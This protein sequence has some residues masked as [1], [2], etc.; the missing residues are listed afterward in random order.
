[1]MSKVHTPYM[2]RSTHI[3]LPYSNATQK[4]DRFKWRPVG[5]DFDLVFIS[6]EYPDQEIT[7]GSVEKRKKVLLIF[8]LRPSIVMVKKGWYSFMLVNVACAGDSFTSS[9][10]QIKSPENFAESKPA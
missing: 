9:L 8:A 4:T 6:L 3:V 5:Y 7:L 10:P 2:V 1:M